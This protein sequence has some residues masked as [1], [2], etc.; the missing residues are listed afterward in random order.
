MF[1]TKLTGKINDFSSLAHCVSDH[2]VGW[3]K[4]YPQYMCD[5]INH[6]IEINAPGGEYPISV[7]AHKGGTETQ[8]LGRLKVE[9]GRAGG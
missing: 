8:K 3:D 1:S 4:A 9:A 5:G 2:K 7:L 6:S